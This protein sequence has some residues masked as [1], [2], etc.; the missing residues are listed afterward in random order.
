M[1]STIEINDTLQITKEQG[2]PAELEVKK[3][4][5]QPY[6][7]ADFQ[8][9]VFEF[10][11]KPNIRFYHMPPVRV[12]LVENL[13]G[14]WIYWG[15]VHILETKHDYT[16]KTTSGKYKIIYL[17]SP[18]EMKEAHKL[19]DRNPETSYFNPD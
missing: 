5:E 3:H 18:E 16:N 7:L 10:R 2:F 15:L 12:F 11:D 9:K 17:N 4:L 1:G 13:N 14:K 6:K 8:N 19:I